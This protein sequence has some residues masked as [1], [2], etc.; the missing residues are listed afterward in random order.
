MLNRALIQPDPAIYLGMVADLMQASAEGIS[1]DDVFLRLEDAEIMLR[2]DR[3][4]TPTMAKAPTL[5]LWELEQL[6]T[7]ENVVRLGHIDT[8]SRGRIDFAQDRWRSHETL[9]SSIA[10]RTG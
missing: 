1:L 6:R 2:I 10:P 7:I 9:S 5:G 4:V 8:V 3:A